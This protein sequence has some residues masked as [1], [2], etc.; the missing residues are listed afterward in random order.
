MFEQ[1]APS[2]HFAALR[3]SKPV[4]AFLRPRHKAFFH[5]FHDARADAM[6]RSVGTAS[7]ATIAG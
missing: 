7:Q 3:Y 1:L 4:S 6:R 5:A 2:L